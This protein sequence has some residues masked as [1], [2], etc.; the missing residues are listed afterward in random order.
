MVGIA[1]GQTRASPGERQRADDTLIPPPCRARLQ[2]LDLTATSWRN[3]ASSSTPALRVCRFPAEFHADQYRRRL[4][5][6][7][8][9]IRAAVDFADEVFPPPAEPRSRSSTT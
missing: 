1:D 5:P 2:V 8:A 7:R 9:E 4:G 3:G 6:A